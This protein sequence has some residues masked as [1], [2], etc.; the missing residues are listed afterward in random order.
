MYKV[1]AETFWHIV[2]TQNSLSCDCV[3]SLPPLRPPLPAQGTK[4]P[5]IK[6]AGG[7]PERLPQGGDIYAETG[8]MSRLWR[9]KNIPDKG[10]VSAK[11]LSGQVLSGGR[12]GAA[13]EMVKGG[14]GQ[15]AVMTVPCQEVSFCG[16]QLGLPRNRGEN[17]SRAFW[18]AFIP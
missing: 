16:V 13:W 7:G 11:V 8:P 17:K 2:R 1:D 3:L 14:R 10:A 6:G 15:D 12:R 9:C 18:S 4:E 5:D